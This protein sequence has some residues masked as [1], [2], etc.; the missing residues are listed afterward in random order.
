[1]FDCFHGWP[2]EALVNV[3]QR[4]LADIPNVE[5]RVL[6]GLPPSL[7]HLRAVVVVVAVVRACVC[8]ASVP[9]SMPCRPDCS[10]L[11]HPYCHPHYHPHRPW[12]SLTAAHTPFPPPPLLRHA[13]EE[14]RDNIANHMAYAHSCVTEASVRF[15]EAF[16]RYNYTTPKSYLELISLYKELLQVGGASSVAACLLLALAHAC[17][18]DR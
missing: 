2:Q 16:R 15:L 7:L 3:A 11:P 9:S 14:V 6:A 17:L 8:L 4:F 13:Q 5:V 1:M 18:V 10:H 12:R